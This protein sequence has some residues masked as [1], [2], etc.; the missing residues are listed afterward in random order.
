[1]CC[2]ALW[3]EDSKGTKTSILEK[4]GLQQPVENIDS[5]TNRV[6]SQVLGNMAAQLGIIGPEMS[7]PFN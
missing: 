2:R 6:L 3:R 1:M 7:C 4:D 5:G